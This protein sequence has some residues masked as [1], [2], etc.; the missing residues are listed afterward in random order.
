MNARMQALQMYYLHQKFSL[1]ALGLEPT[2]M[3]APKFSLAT[4]ELSDL[5]THLA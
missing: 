4:L 2:H 5:L 1:V 3:N